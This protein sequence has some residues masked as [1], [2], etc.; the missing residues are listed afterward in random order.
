[1]TLLIIDMD[2][3]Y[4]FNMGLIAPLFTVSF[5]EK[6][7][8]KKF[9]KIFKS[10]QV[11]DWLVKWIIM[12]QFMD[13]RWPR[14]FRRSNVGLVRSYYHGQKWCP[15]KRSRSE[16]KGQVTA[17]NTLLS[18]FR[19]L[20]SVWIDIWQWNHAHSWKQHRRGVL[21]FCKVIRQISRS[22]GSKD[23]R[24]W[25]KLGVCGLE[26]QFKCTNGYE[27]MHKAWSSIEEVPYFFQGHPSNFKVTR[28]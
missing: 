11:C 15:C 24:I 22:H 10:W 8:K 20:T 4:Q 16:V 1:M 18:R 21:L 19:T 2:C 14:V 6:F 25:P 12:L 3:L 5:H 27:M 23:R 28:L 7:E 9:L 26:L 13:L 17:I